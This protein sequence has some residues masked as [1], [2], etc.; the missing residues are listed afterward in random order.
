MRMTVTTV[1]ELLCG[2]I[3][4]QNGVYF[5]GDLVPAQPSLW[6]CHFGAACIVV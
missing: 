6:L 4:P 5:S 1:D 3:P 2:I